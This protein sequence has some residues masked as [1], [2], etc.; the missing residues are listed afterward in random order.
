MQ[1]GLCRRSKHDRSS[2]RGLEKP[3]IQRAHSV[4]VYQA[5]IT[6]CCTGRFFGMVR[7]STN[8]GRKA[9]PGAKVK[10]YDISG[11]QFVHASAHLCTY[12]SVSCQPQPFVS[13]LAFHNK[14]TSTGPLLARLRTFCLTQHSMQGLEY[15]SMVVGS[16]WLA[17]MLF[18]SP[19]SSKETPDPHACNCH[20]FVPRQACSC[21]TCKVLLGSTRQIVSQCAVCVFVGK[22]HNPNIHRPLPS[23]LCK[24]SILRYYI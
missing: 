16:M 11:S 14:M 10:V 6:N 15:M 4:P 18:T 2:G 17:R 24:D 23:D 5:W 3:H 19:T 8:R 13:K 12:L 7:R 20:C 22:M 9:G 1:L 21:A